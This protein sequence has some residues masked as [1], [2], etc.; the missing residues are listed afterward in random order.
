MVLI[1]AF[2]IMTSILGLGAATILGP[3]YIMSHGGTKYEHAA[4]GTV[5][6]GGHLFSLL[7][8]P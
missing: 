4:A 7:S 6:G 5:H 2:F 8:R 3:D 1:G